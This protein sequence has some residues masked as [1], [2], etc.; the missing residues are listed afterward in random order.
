MDQ[1][2]PA[3]P[4]SAAVSLI[5]THTEPSS[6]PVE[7]AP[8]ADPVLSREEFWRNTIRAQAASGKTISEFCRERGLT[9]SNFHRWKRTISEAVVT[10]AT[11][12]LPAQADATANDASEQLPPSALPSQ[13]TA[14]LP[15]FAEIRLSTLRQEKSAPAGLELRCGK[16]TLTVS[17]DCDRPLLRE[18][19]VLLGEVSC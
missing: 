16:F 15:R 18:V 14:P 8:A 4:D 13:G 6:A 12:T 3:S 7:C 10:T 1:P 9:Y 11:P 2:I 19:L 17:A 5:P